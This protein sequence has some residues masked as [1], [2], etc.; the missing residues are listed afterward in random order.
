VADKYFRMKVAVQ[1]CGSGEYRMTDAVDSC[2]AKIGDFLSPG[3]S[4]PSSKEENPQ[5]RKS[6]RKF[7]AASVLEFSSD[8][9]PPLDQRDLVES[10]DICPGPSSSRL[11]D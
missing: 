8:R 1:N 3:Y 2:S 11:A 6:K 7:T 9:P 5:P 4:A 10:I